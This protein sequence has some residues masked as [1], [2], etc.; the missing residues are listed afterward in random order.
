M[1][2]LIVDLTVRSGARESLE[3]TYS[4]VFR[5]AISKQEGFQFV[6]LLRPDEEGKGYRLAIGFAS[7]PLQQKWVASDLHQ[8]VWPQIESH[9]SG[10]TVDTYRSV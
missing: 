7:Q 5:P 4:N 6:E 3:A 10:F 8:Q 1:F 9:L 2:I